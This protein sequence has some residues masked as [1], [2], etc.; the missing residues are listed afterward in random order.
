MCYN[1]TI[2]NRAT[3]LAFRPKNR[4]PPIS[5]TD[6]LNQW[7]NNGVEP[8]LPDLSLTSPS[9]FIFPY[10]KDASTKSLAVY[11]SKIFLSALKTHPQKIND[12]LASKMAFELKQKSKNHPNEKE[13]AWFLAIS[14]AL[15]SSNHFPQKSMEIFARYLS[16][17]TNDLKNKN[18]ISSLLLA[19]EGI[20][21]SENTH[22]PIHSTTEFLISMVFD[23]LSETGKKDF[24]LKTVGH[25]CNQERFDFATRELKSDNRI[26]P[27][28]EE[29]HKNLI[30]FALRNG[31]LKDVEKSLDV[32]SDKKF[33]V[34]SFCNVWTDALKIEQ[35]IHTPAHNLLP[36]AEVFC[37]KISS[38]E[39]DDLI[40]LFQEKG[41]EV[42][43][44][45]ATL[46]SHNDHLQTTRA[47]QGNETLDPKKNIFSRVGV[48]P[49]VSPS[50]KILNR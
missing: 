15:N 31:S 20:T 36:Q 25:Y 44:L 47:L 49:S 12:V 3:H 42:S 40:L 21:F 43:S 2:I 46:I 39:K 26:L 32:I 27:E 9:P 6:F 7:L 14:D 34:R 17:N 37:N 13:D 5:P 8:D 18:Q 33:R 1:K 11:F 24:L 41:I 30:G 50:P 29:F 4:I 38:E 16:E 35:E 28:N 23:K 48:S 22:T 10:L 19:L 45:P